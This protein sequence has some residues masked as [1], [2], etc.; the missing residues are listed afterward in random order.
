MTRTALPAPVMEAIQHLLATEHA[1]V[2]GYGVIAS[3]TSGAQKRAALSAFDAHRARRDQLRAMVVADG[4]V[5]VESAAA[6]KLPYAVRTPQA[7]TKLAADTEREFGLA[8]GA[9]VEASTS[10]TRDFA[11]SALQ[12]TAVRESY[13]R[14]SAPVLPGLPAPVEPSASPVPTN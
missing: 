4:G 2:Y 5:P 1:A 7:A 9:L 11:A 10:E 13:W 14:G 12:E 3:Q 8:L 6:Y